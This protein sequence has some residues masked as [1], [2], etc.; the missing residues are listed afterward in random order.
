MKK[1]KDHYFHKAK[2]DG[3]VARS[4]YKLEEIEKKHRLL[5]G[6]QRILDL[7]CCPGSWLQ[8]VSGRLK[9]NGNIVGLDLQPVTVKLPDNVK[10]LQQDIFE[11]PLDGTFFKEPFDLILSD[12]APKTTGIKNVDNQRSYDLCVHALRVADIYLKNG[13]NLLVKYFQGQH[14]QQL[15]TDFQKQYQQ[16]HII[17]PQSSRSESV[18]IF[19]LGMNKKIQDRTILQS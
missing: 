14:F 7:G 19:V 16:V 13:G 9:G 15:K 3:Y 2:H 11:I 10:V 1:V 18:E 4:A 17:K 8:Y 12:M 5:K 6:G